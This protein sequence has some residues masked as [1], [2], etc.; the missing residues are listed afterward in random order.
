MNKIFPFLNWLPLAKKS[1]KDDIIAGITG[2][3]IVIPQAVAFAM[4]AGLPPIYG[5]YTAMITPII[6]ALFGS[7]YHLISGPTTA[8]SIVVYATLV[9]LKLNPTTDL[10]AFVSMALV[11]TFLAGLFQFIM[12]LLR[13]GKL[14]NFV[15]H[16]VIIGFTAGA[17]IL[18]AFKQLK[19]VFGIKVPQGSTIVETVTHIGK[20]ISETNWYVF[21]VAIGTL[22]I[23]LIIKF[24]IKP[25][26]RYY[27]LIAM[28]L[29]SLLAIFLG[30]DANGIETVDNIPSNL[31][32]FRIPDLSFENIQLL[33]SGAMV[34]ALLGLIEA[35]AIGRS[36]ALHT[37]QR[38]DGN[39]E[40]IGQGLSNLIASFFSSYAGSGSF[41]RS[42]VNH[43]AGAKTP[44][45]GIFASLFLMVVLL[46]FAKYASFLPKA[47]MGGIILLVG[48]NLID[49]H[50][51]KQVWKSSGKELIV[52]AITLLGTLF[53]DLEFAL[54]AGIFTSFFFYME[55]TSKPNIASLA[56]NKENRLV[57]SI[58]DNDAI[59]CSNLKIVRIDG[60]LYF[61]SI[62]KI[63]DF[64]SSEYEDDNI[65]HILIAANGINFIDLGAAEWLTNEVLKW[66][67]NRGGI[68]I[69]DLKIV[70]QDVLKKGGFI[71]KMGRDIFF[72]D[73]KSAIAKIHEKIDTP[74]AIKAFEECKI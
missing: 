22:V 33:S 14:V 67:K 54:L 52:L 3:I 57:N 21:M 6:A 7:S 8:I 17:G 43:Q 35:V 68:Y 15:S 49:F 10:E 28:V 72:S 61:G 37:H 26:S 53:F 5:F 42:G 66:Q 48:Y 74:C 34:L 32:P 13:M 60:S 2:T 69:A 40:F 47:A 4:I 58:R 41:T 63:A 65:Q 27:M 51:I 25:L 38:I 46:L 56:M 64:F 70:S 19:H 62:E 45:S 50:H 73:K 30:G 18:I 59:E 55:R 31:P 1:W 44:M 12:G 20:H 24:L 23:A 9:K 29:G 11:L 39:Q 36:I 71:E 16:S